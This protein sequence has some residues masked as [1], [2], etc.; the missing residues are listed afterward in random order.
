MLPFSKE[1]IEGFWSISVTL[2]MLDW[3]V[4]YKDGNQELGWW[5]LDYNYI[6]TSFWDYSYINPVSVGIEKW[7]DL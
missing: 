7:K 2:E 4:E 5:T 1:W 3:L 6:V